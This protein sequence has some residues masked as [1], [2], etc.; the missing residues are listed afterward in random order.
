MFKTNRKAFIKAS[1]ENLIGGPQSGD[2]FPKKLERLQKCNNTFD[3]ISELLDEIIIHH[4]DCIEYTSRPASVDNKFIEILT[5]LESV[6]RCA[7]ERGDIDMIDSIE[8][9]TSKFSIQEPI[10]SNYLK[11][12]IKSLTLEELKLLVKNMLVYYI[13]TNQL[14]KQPEITEIISNIEYLKRQIEENNQ[15]KQLFEQPIDFSSFEQLKAANDKI[16]LYKIQLE[17]SDEYRQS[18]AAAQM[19]RERN[20]NKHMRRK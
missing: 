1:F 14:E 13:M 10:Y 19:I 20:I 6:Y 2:L 18:V 9:G 3:K 5:T 17:N 4:C 7:K 8:K 15:I 16:E 12:E 11:S